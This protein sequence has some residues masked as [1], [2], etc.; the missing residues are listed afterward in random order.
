MGRVQGRRDGS[1]ADTER[2]TDRGVVEVGVVAKED[3][4]SLA[5]RHRCKRS[6][7]LR[8]HLGMAVRRRRGLEAER[9][10]GPAN[11]RPRRIQH[12][13]PDPS[14]ERTVAPERAALAHRGRERLLHGVVRAFGVARRSCAGPGR[15]RPCL[16]R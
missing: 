1:G 4:R 11:V 8:V 2:L 5:L 15:P 14:L 6:A 13:A 16:A 9:R 12:D 3:G 10:G 7:Q